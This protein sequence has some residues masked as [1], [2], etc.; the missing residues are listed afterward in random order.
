M[1]LN[2]RKPSTSIA[3]KSSYFSNS[4][5]PFPTD[6]FKSWLQASAKT[7]IVLL[8]LNFM[9]ATSLQLR[10]HSHPYFVMQASAQANNAGI[11]RVFGVM[12]S[13]PMR[14]AYK[15][16]IQKTGGLML[17]LLNCWSSCWS[18]MSLGGSNQWLCRLFWLTLELLRK[19][20]NSKDGTFEEHFGF[21]QEAGR[22]W[23]HSCWNRFAFKN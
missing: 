11:K 10:I 23:S 4:W 18:I 14:S 20:L 17:R 7:T 1:N 21:G 2:E 13:L 5:F 12:S 6:Y 16:G 22:V 15:L 9:L 3:I 19:K 8:S